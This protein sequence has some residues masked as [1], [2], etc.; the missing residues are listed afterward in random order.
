MKRIIISV[1]I[2]TAIILSSIGIVFANDTE[3]HGWMKQYDDVSRTQSTSEQ[4]K[5]NQRE[6]QAS[7]SVVSQ[8]EES[9]NSSDEPLSSTDKPVKNDNSSDS[10]VT[11]TVKD[12]DINNMLGKSLMPLHRSVAILLIGGNDY[13]TKHYFS[14]MEEVFLNDEKTNVKVIMGEPVQSKYQEYWLNKGFLEEQ[15]PQKDNLLEFVSFAGVDEILYLIVKDPVVDTHWSRD[16]FQAGQRSRAS[17]Q[18][19]SF[20]AKADSIIR[21]KAANNEDDSF[22]SELR[23]KR[24]AFK[25]CMQEVADS[26]KPVW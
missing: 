26:M 22:A 12:I 17:I 7:K 16:V 11:T 15:I 1:L 18:V 25:K 23:A 10:A 24:G 20:L 2:T 8:K 9:H 5:S 13:K 19:N 3:R 14:I 21:V 6:K 4:F